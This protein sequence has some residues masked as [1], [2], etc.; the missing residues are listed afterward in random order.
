MVIFW[1][2]ITNQKNYLLQDS[3]ILFWVYK[4]WKHPLLPLRII[5]A[6]ANTD[7]KIEALAIVGGVG[8]ADGGG[9]GGRERINLV[10]NRLVG[11]GKRESFFTFVSVLFEDKVKSSE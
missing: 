7:E 1:E 3:V 4:F 6:W 2:D 5:F 9:G 10:W 8:W 11:A